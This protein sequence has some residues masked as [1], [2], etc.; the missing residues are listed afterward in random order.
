MERVT[1]EIIRASTPAGV[2]GDEYR[3]THGVCILRDANDRLLAQCKSLATTWVLGLR[4]TRDHGCWRRLRQVVSD[5]APD[6]V[7]AL[8]TGTWIDTVRATRGRKRPRL[9]LSFHGQTSLAPIG[10]WRRWLN[11]RAAARADV[12]LSVSKEAA[13][14]LCQEWGLPADKV[15][16]IPNGVDVRRFRP[17]ADMDERLR[18]RGKLNV[19]ATGPL[20]ICVANLVPIKAIDVLLDGW[21]GVVASQP[22]ACL[23][24]VGQGPMRE[25]LLQLAE[26][27]QLGTAVRFLGD[28]DDVPALL[29]AADLFVLSSRYEACSMA[30]LEAMAS[31]LPVVSTAAGGN[32]ELV[33]PGKTGW[34]VEA[35]RADLLSDAVVAALA[36]ESVRQRY[37]QAALA[38]ALDRHTLEGCARQYAMLYRSLAFSNGQALP[39]PVEEPECAG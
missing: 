32:G 30:T 10:W 19:P 34:L 25:Q 37:G 16:T 1:L 7:E 18:V 20:A 6:V 31:G 8:S 3:I 28:R 35:D 24:I 4:R 39:A 17:P 36:D 13:G 33:I 26:Q 15:R 38:T 21:R 5:F 23:L 2:A 14:R 29:R 9:V 12:V 11:R 22:S 27:L